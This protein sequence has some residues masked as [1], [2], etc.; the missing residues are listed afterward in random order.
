MSRNMGEQTP[1]GLDK[2]KRYG[3]LS[4]N[5]PGK[6]VYVAKESLRVDQTYQRSLNDS[7]R[8]RIASNFNWAA[9]GVLLCA[10]RPD[11]TLWVIDGQ[12]R[13][14]AAMSRSD[15]R[16]VPVVVFQ[17]DG[18]IQDEAA[19]F[20]IANKERKPLTGV[21][22][23][24]A[25]VAAGDPIAIAVNDMVHSTG[26]VIGTATD[27]KTVRCVAMLYSCMQS[28]ATAMKQLWPFICEL[29]ADEPIDNR[30]VA[31]LHYLETRL[32][33]GKDEDCS[34]LETANRSKL[35]D[36]GVKKILR[37]IGDAAA[38]Y[39][40]GGAGVFAKGILNVVNYKRRNVLRM[41]GSALD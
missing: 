20:L 6:L 10:R 9:M 37:A 21:D 12:H 29:C 17:F 39:H 4:K 5:E 34:I 7:K 41:R 33:D 14:A 32:V 3:W 19:D 1:H 24:K 25:Q 40:R 35:L 36:A 11:G 22:S 8:K 26:R 16:D 31:G 27:N 18:N 30:F 13:L 38:Y 28:N 15:V 2:I 23:F